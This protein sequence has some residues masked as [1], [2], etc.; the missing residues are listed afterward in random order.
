M[1]LGW[2]VS[3]SLA[4][5]QGATADQHDRFRYED[6]REETIAHGFADLKNWVSLGCEAITFV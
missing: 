5:G 3:S 6:S 2:M 1:R 4:K